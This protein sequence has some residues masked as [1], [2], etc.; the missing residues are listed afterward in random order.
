VKAADVKC[1]VP[2]VSAGSDRNVA[3]W[4]SERIAARY[5]AEHQVHPGLPHWI[6]AKSALDE[7]APPVVAW[8]HATLNVTIP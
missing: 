5:N 6:I 1:P 4:I 2:C 8:L 3:P 7:V